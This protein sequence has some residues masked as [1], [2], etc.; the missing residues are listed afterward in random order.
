MQ[1]TGVRQCN[2][3]VGLAR[4]S[5]QLALLRDSVLIIPILRRDQL[6]Q[7]VAMWI[8]LRMNF[9]LLARF[10]TFSSAQASENVWML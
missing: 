2:P 4:L 3:P 7:Q 10:C 5:V 6:M 9:G 8:M 1:L